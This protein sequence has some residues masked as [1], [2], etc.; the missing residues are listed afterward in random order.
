MQ[1]SAGFFRMMLVC[2]LGLP[3]LGPRQKRWLSFYTGR[4]VC[5]NF[6]LFL[7]LFCYVALVFLHGRQRFF[8]LVA[9]LFQ[10]YPQSSSNSLEF[11]FTLVLLSPPTCACISPSSVAPLFIPYFSV[12]M[13]SCLFHWLDELDGAWLSLP[14]KF[15]AWLACHSI[16]HYSR[17]SE[18]RLRK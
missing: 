8:S 14:L 2:K 1:T 7:L 16:Y 11:S 18:L 17:S 4:L 6:F 12:L 13:C 15:S 5:D 10:K 3:K 9:G